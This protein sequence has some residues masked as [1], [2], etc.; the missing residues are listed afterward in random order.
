VIFLVAAAMAADL[1]T[2]SLVVPIVGGEAEVNP[3]MH[4]GYEMFGI[5]MVG[6]L[7]VACT[8]AIILLVFR[9]DPGPKRWL[10]ASVGIFLGLV[11][12]FGNITAFM[13][14]QA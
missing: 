10:A 12:A 3:I 13:G 14:S 2:F 8:V 11:G 9:T 5:L 7:K 6:L 4:Q 1:L